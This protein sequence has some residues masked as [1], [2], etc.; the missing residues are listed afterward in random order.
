MRATILNAILI[1]TCLLFATNAYSQGVE[2]TNGITYLVNNQSQT[3]SWGNTAS[4]INNEY[5]STLA[6]LEALKQLG[7]DNT[8]AYQ[9]GLQWLQTENL[10]NTAYIAYKISI[11]ANTGTDITTETNTLMSY[12]N[13]DNGWG[14]F[15][16]YKSNN[17]HTSL[18]LPA[19]KAINYSDQNIISS[20]ITFLTSTQ[21][22]DGG[23]GFYP[24]PCSG[25]EGDD[26][27]VYMTALV[28]NTFPNS[29]QPTT[30]KRQSTMQSLIF[31]QNKTLTAVSV[32]H[33]RR[34]TKL[35]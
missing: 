24:S 2:I 32:A 21:N 19:L 14:G 29:S 23:W 13:T 12:K 20:A 9:N 22:L 26:S 18:A 30:F 27:N 11:L 4:S 3:G 10:I 35:H 28:L 7:Q 6:V 34:C 17:F 5:F 8:T 33:L 25:C 15:L 1:V 16:K 31:S